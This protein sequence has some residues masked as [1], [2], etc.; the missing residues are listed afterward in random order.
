M[1]SHVSTT[2][3]VKHFAYDFRGHTSGTLG[4]G[5]ACGCPY[6]KGPA[7]FFLSTTSEKSFIPYKP[8]ATVQALKVCPV[9][10][11]VL[12]K[13]GICYRRGSL[14]LISEKL[15]SRVSSAT[16]SSL[17]FSHHDIIYQ[18]YCKCLV[19]VCRAE[20]SLALRAPRMW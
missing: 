13:V 8:S 11:R 9:Q 19:G 12:S 14:V 6:Y 20:Q 16:C 2:K 10:P 15:R 17:S 7:I 5:I 4:V 3:D 1:I 18:H